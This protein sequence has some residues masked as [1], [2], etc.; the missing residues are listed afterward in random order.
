MATSLTSE[1]E[2]ELKQME[3]DLPPRPKSPTS[4]FIGKT[5]ATTAEHE[6]MLAKLEADVGSSKLQEEEEYQKA[7]EKL[8]KRIE[9]M[10]FLSAKYSI[11]KEHF[12]KYIITSTQI[13]N[14]KSMTNNEKTKNFKSL[15][16]L[17]DKVFNKTH[18]D[19]NNKETA[20]FYVYKSLK[21]KILKANET[22]TK[23]EYKKFV[24]QTLGP[25]SVMS[26]QT[27]MFI[28]TYMIQNPLMAGGK[29]RKSR[30]Q[31]KSR[32]KKPAHTRRR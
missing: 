31:R 9:L 5:T 22:S 10:N 27:F 18:D 25:V 4:A 11:L 14:H 7:Q 32:R 6:K 23:E 17:I 30:K 16:N 15:I 8:T 28:K 20:L 19:N 29:S 13:T 2:A 24:E 1:E 3:E 26:L 21:V 12:N